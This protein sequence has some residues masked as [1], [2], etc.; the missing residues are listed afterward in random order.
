MTLARVLYSLVVGTA[1]FLSE[2][3]VILH[4]TFWSK[5]GITLSMNKQDRD[6]F[7]TLEIL[8]SKEFFHL[9]VNDI[10]VFAHVHQ[11]MQTI[12]RHTAE[13]IAEIKMSCLIQS[14]MGP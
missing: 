2:G 8:G 4:C 9:I 14:A 7:Q 6:S 10:S 11:M 3:I 13:E 5:D 1:E 12:H